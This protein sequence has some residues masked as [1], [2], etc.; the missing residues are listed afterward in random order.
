MTF[1]SQYRNWVS[2]LAPACSS[3]AGRVIADSAPARETAR[4]EA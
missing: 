1:S 2:R 4:A 3:E